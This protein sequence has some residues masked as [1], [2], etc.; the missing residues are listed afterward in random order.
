MTLKHPHSF[1]AADAVDPNPRFVVDATGQIMALVNDTTT[2]TVVASFRHSFYG[3]VGAAT[4]AE[5]EAARLNAIEPQ[6]VEIPYS[7][8]TVGDAFKTTQG[9]AYLRVSGGAVALDTLVH[10]GTGFWEADLL[11][12]RVNATIYTNVWG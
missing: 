2:G 11:V 5:R 7:K 9:R 3:S 4:A 1:H 6:D 8:L 12:T 10:Y